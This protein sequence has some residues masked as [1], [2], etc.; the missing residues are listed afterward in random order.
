[1]IDE[2]LEIRPLLIPT[3]YSIGVGGG[4]WGVGEIVQY[5]ENIVSNSYRVDSGNEEGANFKVFIDDFAY[6]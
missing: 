6:F 4:E 3:V 1:M 2:N 5:L